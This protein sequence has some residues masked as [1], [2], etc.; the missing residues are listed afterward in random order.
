MDELDALKQH[1]KSNT[2]IATEKK[3]SQK[4]I[5]IM[6]RHN[7]SSILKTLWYISIA[8]LVIFTTLSLLPLFSNAYKVRFEN[9]TLNKD[10]VNAL[11]FTSLIIVVVFVFILY[12]SYKSISVTDT[13]KKLMHSILTT[14]KTVNYYVIANLILAFIITVSLFYQNIYSSQKIAEHSAQYT[15]TNWIVLI[16]S[17]LIATIGFMAIIWLFYKLLYGRLTKQLKANYNELLELK[18]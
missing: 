2:E 1:W 11:N 10:V 18:H 9:T 3:M 15:L 12:K 13:S 14:I 8:E 5:Y 7:S 16:G 4:D 17:G 6:L